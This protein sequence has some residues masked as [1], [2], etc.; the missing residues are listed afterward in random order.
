MA[1]DPDD[2]P[3]EGRILG[4]DWG[5]KR[6]GLAISDPT[7]RIA[8]PLATLTR[9]KG[10]RFPMRGLRTHL[11]AH[12]LVG[13]VIG[14]PL[15]S[16]GDE[17]RAAHE[18]RQMGSDIHEKT[19]LPVTYVDERMTTARALRAIEELGGKTAGREGMVDQ[20]A[21]TVLLQALLD[22]RRA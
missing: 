4:I 2:F 20:L 14:L 13:I 18:V 12:R 3:N 7:Q 10:R 22:R 19:G 11:D 15:T 5:E 8:Q 17:G 9:R 1:R 16:E 21:A 6:F